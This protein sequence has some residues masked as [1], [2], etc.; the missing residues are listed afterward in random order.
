VLPSADDSFSPGGYPGASTDIRSHTGT[1]EQASDPGVRPQ[2]DVYAP[3]SLRRWMLPGRSP[4]YDDCWPTRGEASHAVS[5]SS[6]ASDGDDHAISVVIADDQRLVRAGFRVI[7]A[8][9]PG[10]RVVGEAADG[11]E[12]I[13]LARALAPAVILMDVRMP[14]MDGL[15]AAQHILGSCDSR[16]LILTTFDADE[17]VYE[18]L[19]MGASGFLLKDAPPEQLI[20]AV[21]CAAA[22]DALID[23][24]ITRRL[25][26]RFAHAVRPPALQP[27]QLK[28]L[29]ERELDV[30]RLVAR[31]HT[32]AEIAVELV[33][34]ESTVK[35]HV[36]RILMK[37]A[38]RD[39]VQAVV[40]AY[41][42]GFVRP[43]DPAGRS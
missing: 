8:G 36:S 15:A 20:A 17:Y 37:L 2:D 10:I 24:S 14:N 32:N 18:A 33:V 41:E 6:S 30:L 39:R 31:G 16:V 26:G 34:E 43:D 22:G 12:A 28:D 38:L 23:P 21:R 3:V 42:S 9:E 27:A 25:I 1:L 40:V 13:E 11:L 29:T 4:G 19:R 5:M 35:T 7:L